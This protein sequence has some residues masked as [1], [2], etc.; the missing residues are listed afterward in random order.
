MAQQFLVFD[1]ETTSQDWED[2]SESQQEYLMRGLE[3]E[4][5]QEK[6][7]WEMA[8]TPFTGRVVCIGLM[9]VNKNDANDYEIINR[10]TFSTRLDFEGDEREEIDLATG[11]KCYVNSEKN[12]LDDF[13]K[14]LNK[15]PSA[16]L[17]TFNG[18]N[19]DCPFLM[20]RSAVFNI[21]PSR[22]LMAGT[23]FNYPL[24]ID[25]ADELTFYA[26]FGFGATKR[27]NFDFYA[28]SFGITSPKSEGVDGSMVNELYKENKIEEIAEYCLRDVS[29]TWELF[30]IWNNYLRF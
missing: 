24:H 10:A 13:W 7:K 11:D 27:F 29:A 8:L 23:K 5:E 22:N 19:F 30:K 20:L 18:R 21:R 4:E 28:R 12:T 25:L 3:T 2:F 15:Y 17:V 16:Q 14:I 1:I 9:L 6:R 26:G